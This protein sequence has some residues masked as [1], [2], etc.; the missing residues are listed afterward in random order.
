MRRC[1]SRKCNGGGSPPPESSN[2]PGPLLSLSTPR[3]DDPQSSS[4]QR[5]F[6]LPVDLMQ[7]KCHFVF[8]M[9]HLLSFVR[10]MCPAHFHF[11]L[12][13]YWTMSVSL[14]RCPMMA[15]WTLYFSLIFS[16][17]LSLALLL[18]SSSFCY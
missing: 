10:A 16:I 18:V 11:A 2:F 4:L 3:S 7:F 17:F 13:T 14:V 15:L 1:S 6:G 5:R 12:V 9:D 8:L